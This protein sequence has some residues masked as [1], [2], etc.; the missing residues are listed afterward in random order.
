MTKVQKIALVGLVGLLPLGALADDDKDCDG[1]SKYFMKNNS[2]II[3]SSNYKFEGKIEKMP[4]KGFNG[5]WIISGKK[6]LVDDNTKIYQ[7]DDKIETK[8]EVKVIAKR[9]NG[10]IK[11]LILIQDD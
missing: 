3:K 2:S 1:K 10:D 6:V 5:T 4:T 8:D 11:A 7:E 9:T